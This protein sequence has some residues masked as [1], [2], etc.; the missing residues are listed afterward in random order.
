MLGGMPHIP[1]GYL[2][3]PDPGDLN[4]QNLKEICHSTFL[5]QM[6]LPNW[7]TFFF[8]FQYTIANST[9]KWFCLHYMTYLYT[10]IV[11]MLHI[12]SH[13]KCSENIWQKV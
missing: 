4:F 11:Q 6:D 12:F 8:F 5:G 7:I 3:S 9:L 13:L 1:G 10:D 2:N